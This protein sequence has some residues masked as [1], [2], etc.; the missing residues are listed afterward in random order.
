MLYSILIVLIFFYVH[1]NYSILVINAL[2]RYKPAESNKRPFVSVLIAAKNEEKVI[3]KTLQA[4]KKSDYPKM[5]IIVIDGNSTD[6]TRK[7]AKKYADKIIVDKKSIGKAYS[8]N[9]A[10]KKAKGSV[11]YII[12]ADCI[13]KKD[14]IRIVVSALSDEYEAAAGVII[15]I[16]KGSIVSKIGRLECAGMD[17]LE[18][19]VRRILGTEMI[20]GRNFAIYKKTI[21]NM[22]G[23]KNVL[24][25]D[26]NIT[27]RLYE[28]KKKVNF[29]PG[30]CMEQCPD[31]L[32][33][34]WRQHERWYA[35]GTGELGK[36]IKKL[37][38]FELLILMPLFLIASNVIMIS[39]I[40][41]ITGFLFNNL[42]LLAGTAL[43]F[44]FFLISTYRF[45]DKDELLTLPVV[46]LCAGVIQFSMLINV[47][48]KKLRGEQIVWYITPKKKIA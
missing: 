11:L 38:F 4:L 19:V 6:S 47:F 14:T 21:K 9:L 42:F 28:M 13:V 48:I 43:G 37:S 10:I 34:Y 46:F 33:W 8:L 23:F 17:S 41:L 24:C 2:F 39:V 15:P 40:M 27:L 36:V 25:E 26:A 12:D 7:I 1:F 45:L 5:E 18:T 20:V 44:A 29:A 30:V 32:K 16:N 22:S 3:E 31:K 35:G